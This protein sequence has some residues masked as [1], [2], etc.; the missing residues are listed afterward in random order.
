MLAV[1]FVL[2]LDDVPAEVEGCFGSLMG[3]EGAPVGGV[4]AVPLEVVK[5]KRVPPWMIGW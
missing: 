2:P 4:V 3:H 1:D 5:R